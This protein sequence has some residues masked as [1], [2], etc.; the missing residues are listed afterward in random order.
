M[1]EPVWGWP[2]HGRLD[3]AGL[4]LPNG[5]VLGSVFMPGDSPWL[6]YRHQVPGVAPVQRSEEEL[7]A[8]Q[9]A[10]REW[11]NQTIL[12]GR[13][14]NLYN[15]DLG[16][17]LYSA[18][19]GSNWIINL[20][21]ETATLFGVLGG[22]SVVKPLTVTWPADQGQTSPAIPG[23]VVKR[24]NTPV[25]ISP[26]GRQ[27]VLMLYMEEPDITIP[28]GTRPIPL[29]FL[30]LTVTGDRG[31]PFAATAT[32]ARTRAQTLGSYTGLDEYT[33]EVR[34]T[35]WT[36]G[37]PYPHDPDAPVVVDRTA[38]SDPPGTVYAG[39]DVNG[40]LGRYQTRQGLRT[41]AV[42]DKILAVWFG[43][44]GSLVDCTLD[45]QIL[46]QW[47]FPAASV[48]VGPSPT[49]INRT[50]STT[51][52][53]SLTLKVGG[54]TAA[55]MGE[56]VVRTER[57]ENQAGT[58]EQSE[59]LNGEDVTGQ[60]SPIAGTWA[61][62]PFDFQNWTQLQ[63]CLIRARLRPFDWVRYS[64]NLF[65]LYVRVQP[66]ELFIQHYRGAAAPVAGAEPYQVRL[67]ESVEPSSIF[68]PLRFGSLN[69]ITGEH[70]APSDGNSIS[71]WM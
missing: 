15:R 5:Q 33:G 67:V 27:A 60:Y 55:Q 50:T 62:V 68:G 54:E 4:H 63:Q 45:F 71:T 38:D 66:A 40:Q 37:P 35:R 34:E 57:W 11:R 39:T 59:T 10:G 21:G 23:A 46:Y 32:V 20:E 31:A 65:G 61:P 8:D 7:E 28:P 9:A 3:G 69:P 56:V 44:D 6:T 48:N 30:L 53:Y 49:S 29:G 43:P 36:I 70:T 17:W 14:F 19:D 24:D 52:T 16:G 1:T 51:T 64:N 22:K 13:G 58:V 12:C 47:D 26:A 42:Q 2:W 18:P 25:D 41:D